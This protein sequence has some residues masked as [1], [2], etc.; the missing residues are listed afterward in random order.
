VISI[1]GPE[2]GIKSVTLITAFGI[3]FV[4]TY[5]VCRYFMHLD[6][7]KRIVWYI[8]GTMCLAVGLFFSGVA[9]D[10]MKSTGQNW[11]NAAALQLIEDHKNG[12]AKKDEH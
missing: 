5:M 9:A 12:A 2:V 7:E 1:L 6:V 8:L 3:A 4:K 11:E 10:V